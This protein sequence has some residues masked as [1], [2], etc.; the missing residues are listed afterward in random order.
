[1]TTDNLVLQNLLRGEL[2]K[3]AGG[4]NLSEADRQ[5]LN[6]YLGVSGNNALKDV[7]SPATSMTPQSQ[8]IVEDKQQLKDKE[9]SVVSE[10]LSGTEKLFLQLYREFVKKDD[11]KQLA[12]E[13]G[14]FSR[15][16]QSELAK[17]SSQ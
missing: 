1:M 13:L 8:P 14:K 5:I 9:S 3:Y 2:V 17:A 6:T 15:F 11:G 12:A 7:I 16:A 4:L 10:G